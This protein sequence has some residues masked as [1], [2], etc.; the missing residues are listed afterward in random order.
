MITNY[1]SSTTVNQSA[2]TS[3]WAVSSGSATLTNTAS[4]QLYSGL[5]SL[6][7]TA[8]S[9]SA[10]TLTTEEVS[11]PTEQTGRLT[12]GFVWI[13][14]TE[15]VGASVTIYSSY[16]GASVT[17]ETAGF[18]VRPL[19]WT[20]LSV[21][22]AGNPPEGTT[23]TARFEIE[24]GNTQANDVYYLAHPAICT[25]DAAVDNEFAAEVWLRCPEYVRNADYEQSDPDFPLLRFLDSIASELSILF[26]YWEDFRYDPPD[27]ILVEKPSAL[28][29]P[30]IAEQAWLGWLA[31]FVGTKLSDPSA[32]SSSWLSL[33]S[34]A[35]TNNDGSTTWKEL[36]DAV[37]GDAT[38]P[39]DA[40]QAP[41]SDIEI[42]APAITN[43]LDNLRWQ[44]SSAAYGFSGGTV[45]ALK[46]AAKQGLTGTQSVTVNANYLG[47]PWAIEVAVLTAEAED[48]GIIQD[49][50]ARATPAG[51]EVT[52]TSS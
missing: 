10:F 38:D 49:L 37:D 16:S 30:T 24:I 3:G 26:S 34:A 18:I 19:R 1:L 35:D 29:D 11:V 42:F 27:D 32:G 21:L 47:D 33:L 22:E 45:G 13:Y 43:L 15:Q 41:W 2:S 14:A 25:P 44:A 12:R 5:N 20:L 39:A 51:F 50:L 17:P 6:Q 31:Q 4:K 7:V 36:L 28:V 9:N 52:V 40:E 8:G 46:E 23:G 48:T